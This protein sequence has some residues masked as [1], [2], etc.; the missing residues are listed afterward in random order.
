MFRNM[1]SLKQYIQT[2]NTPP[3]YYPKDAVSTK[4]SFVCENIYKERREEKRKEKKIN[5]K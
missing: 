5:E 1:I 2:S 4:P 3:I